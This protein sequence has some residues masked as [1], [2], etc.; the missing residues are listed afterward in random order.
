MNQNSKF[1]LFRQLTDKQKECK[2]SCKSFPPASTSTF[3]AHTSVS[4][5]LWTP[6]CGISGDAISSVHKDYPD[7][8]HR[9]SRA[10]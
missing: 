3:R 9:D 7:Y 2:N 6:H 4:S 10:H 8:E 1:Q 5:L